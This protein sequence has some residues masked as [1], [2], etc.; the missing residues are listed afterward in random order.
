MESR[1]I[2]VSNYLD[3]LHLCII[4][5]GYLLK[6]KDTFCSPQTLYEYFPEREMDVGKYTWTLINHTHW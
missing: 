6:L 4:L 2:K 1:K 5:C 3:N